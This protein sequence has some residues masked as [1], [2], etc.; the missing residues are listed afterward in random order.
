MLQFNVHECHLVSNWIN[1]PAK[2]STLLG[3]KHEQKL[4]EAE[5]TII[6]SSALIHHTLSKY[7]QCKNAAWWPTL[8]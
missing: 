8:W 1:K 2:D 5:S 3:G 6:K 4:T 7:R